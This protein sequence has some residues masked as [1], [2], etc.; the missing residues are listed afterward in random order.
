MQFSSLL[1]LLAAVNLAYTR[2][3]SLLQRHGTLPL[4]N[5]GMFPS[6]QTGHY[7]GN[8]PRAPVERRQAPE[9][10][11]CDANSQ[12]SVTAP[13]SNIFAGLTTD[14]TIAITAFLHDQK[15]LNLTAAS[16]ATRQIIT[17]ELLQPNK[18]DALSYLDSGS[19]APVRHARALIRFGATLEPYLQ[20]YLVGP[21]PV[22]AGKT[23][24]AP[25]DSIFNKG[26]GYQRL[27]NVDTEALTAFSYG[28]TS[29]NISDIS[30][31]LLNGTA[32]GDA[33]GTFA[34]A[35]TTP[36]I[37]EGDRVLQ[38]NQ[39]YAL[40]TGACEDEDILPS[41]LMF[42]TDITGRDPSKWSV[43]AL[44]YNGIFYESEADLRKAINSSG[45][46]KPGPNV[47][48]T[49]A[50]TDYNNVS[51]PH[52]ELNPPVSVAP[53]GARFTVDVE[54]KYIEWMDFTFY[55]SSSKY[56]GTQLHN[57]RYKGERI[58]YELGIQEAMAHYASASDPFQAS[59]AY[60][61]SEY[62]FGQT[63]WQLV[64]GFDCP[65]YAT[66]L[67]TSYYTGETTHV[68]PS[69]ICLFEYDTGYPIQRHTAGSYVSV[70]K[71][72]AFTVRSISTVGNYDY[73]F[74]YEFFLDG[75][76]H[77]TVRASGYIE[78]SFWATGTQS[79]DGFHIHDNLAGSMHDHVLNYKV[80]LDVAGTANSVAKTELVPITK[81][82]PWSNGREINTMTID[83]TYLASEDEGKL[84]WDAN[85]NVMY[86]VL[87]KDAVNPYGEYRSY[88]IMP[89]TGN[90]NHLTIQNSTTLGKSAN[91]AT[92]HLYAVQRKDTEPS[93]AYP[94][95]GRDPN[96]PVVDFAKF[97]DGDSLDQEDIV[98]YFNLG[99]HH[100]PD[101]SDLPNTVFT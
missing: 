5:H 15:S 68:H 82:Y 61:D 57:I 24:V 44:Q 75:S 11:G 59:N 17:V 60:L 53:D 3:S 100:I 73:M 80:D 72:I 16:N 81:V 55:L 48:G 21:L 47:D 35:G 42:K 52:D 1:V 22:A 84:S 83:R 36:L 86:S 41:G 79:N 63:G 91:W 43:V 92:H 66:Y 50:C 98:I 7:S 8:G 34:L 13:K 29:T 4:V 64:S 37:F 38:W 54:E 93:S 14:E 101:Q 51:F 71:N 25:L 58:I 32:T 70:T 18:S 20:E 97:F 99:M 23:T 67:N 2:R 9:S 46:V 78:S 33:S 19:Q 30:Q 40:H 56:L 12:L 49:W 76:I 28:Y 27:Y 94:Y 89:A 87:N 85:N 65:V 74:D 90:R 6:T 10:S 62:G 45:F 77:V 88:K 31:Q 26:R 69:S 95:N 39:L 96:N